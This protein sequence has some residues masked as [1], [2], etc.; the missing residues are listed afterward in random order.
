MAG[1]SLFQMSPLEGRSTQLYGRTAWHLEAGV[2]T[3]IRSDFGMNSLMRTCTF[4]RQPSVVERRVRNG[5]SWAPAVK[6]TAAPRPYPT[7]LCNT[8]LQRFASYSWDIKN[9]VNPAGDLLNWA[10]KEKIVNRLDVK[11]NFKTR[12]KFSAI[13]GMLAVSKKTICGPG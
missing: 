5:K 4:F 1:L 6:Y 7:S 10:V 2:F 13:C 11:A 9:V 12:F 8:S 3:P